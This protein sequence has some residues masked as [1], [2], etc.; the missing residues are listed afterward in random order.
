M[1]RCLRSPSQ[2]EETQGF[3]PQLDKDLEIPPSAR[4][5]AGFRFS[6]S[7]AML[8]SP[9]Q[10]EWRL[11][12]PG[13]TQEAPLVPHHISRKTPHVAPQLEKNHE[14]RPSSRD[15]ALIFLQ[16]LESNPESSLQTPQEA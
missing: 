3:L 9:L 15:E 2:I 14:I 6:D 5:E 8:H 4:L 7:R 10:L 13:D 16:G 11:D 12:F 1:R